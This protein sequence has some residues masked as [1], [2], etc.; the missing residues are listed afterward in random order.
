MSLDNMENQ[1]VE[2]CPNCGWPHTPIAGNGY[3]QP[4]AKLLQRM[5]GR[6]YID[7]KGNLKSLEDLDKDEPEGAE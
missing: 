2:R 4:C 5:T 6:G 7:F 1:Q 3:C